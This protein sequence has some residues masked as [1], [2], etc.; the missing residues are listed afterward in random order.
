[1]KQN[2]DVRTINLVGFG[3]ALNIVG[4]FVAL[5]LR[6]PIYLDS[7]GTIMVACLLGPKYAILTGLGGSVVS[8]VTFDIYSLYFAPVQITTGLLA[9]WM[10]QKGWLKGKR[11]PIG[12]LLF[13][14]P[15]SLISAIIAAAVFGGVTSSGSSYIVQVLSVVGVPTVVSVFI[16]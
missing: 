16:V 11:M 6:L 1:M 7:I 9:G 10:F 5:T 14:L 3:I 12:V 2:V 15:T 13:T 8:G 4:A